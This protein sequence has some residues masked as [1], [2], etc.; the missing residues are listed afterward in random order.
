MKKTAVVITVSDRSA[1]GEREDLS[2]PAVISVLREMGFELLAKEVVP[3]DQKRIGSLLRLYAE[4]AALIVTTGGTGIAKRDFTPE[5]TMAVCERLIPGIPEVM[6]AEGM[7]KNP[8]APL[9]RAVCGTRGA[10]LLLNLPGSP[11]GAVESLQAV[12]PLVMHAL[13][14]LAGNTEHS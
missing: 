14:L 8:R 10:A 3:D 2:G 5:A 7:K 1:R 9:S 11:T 6:R 12:L 13:E 4:K